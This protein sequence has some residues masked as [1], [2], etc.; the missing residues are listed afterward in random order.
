[1]GKL[2]VVDLERVRAVERAVHEGKIKEMNG[3]VDLVKHVHHC[4]E[5]MEVRRLVVLL[6]LPPLP[7]PL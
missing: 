3:L 4:A 7:L 5:Q 1:M 6:L 2:V